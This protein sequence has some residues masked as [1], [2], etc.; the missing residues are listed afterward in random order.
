MRRAA[1]H[2][3]RRHRRIGGG[4]EEAALL[5]AHRGVGDLVRGERARRQSVQPVVEDRPDRAVEGLQQQG[6]VGEHQVLDHA[7]VP[8]GQHHGCLR[9]TYVRKVT[10]GSMR[11]GC[12]G[13]GLGQ[14][15]GQRQVGAGTGQF[16]QC[17]AQSRGEP[18]HRVHT[19]VVPPRWGDAVQQDQYTALAGRGKGPGG[20]VLVGVFG[21]SGRGG[22]F[23]AHTASLHE[24]FT[25]S[26]RGRK[27]P[28]P[29]GQRVRTGR[30]G[31][32]RSDAGG[33]PPKGCAE[34]PPRGPRMVRGAPG[35]TCSPTQE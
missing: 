9:R 31:R 1:R 19:T 21:A 4:G 12:T 33:H 3:A 7:F 32:L 18:R 35:E 10:G 30:K 5:V 17:A 8:A 11:V 14:D 13:D 16:H 29:A 6:R 20:P 23:D 24:P 25:I 34:V 22:E 26:A 27:R 2:R 15:L 28:V